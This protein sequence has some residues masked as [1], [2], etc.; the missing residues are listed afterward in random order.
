LVFNAG[1]T[2]KAR[3]EIVTIVAPITRCLTTNI[4]P[5]PQPDYETRHQRIRALFACVIREKI[6][7]RAYWRMPQPKFFKLCRRLAASHIERKSR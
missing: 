7:P 3:N 2:F 6:A 4:T 5:F 1:R